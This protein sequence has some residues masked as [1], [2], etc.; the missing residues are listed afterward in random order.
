M[1][2]TLCAILVSGNMAQTVLAADR[3]ELT[4]YT[5]IQDTS[6]TPSQGYYGYFPA[7]YYEEGSLVRREIPALVQD[8][9][10]YLDAADVCERL[11]LDY[12]AGSMFGVEAQERK[13]TFQKDSAEIYIKMGPSYMKYTMPVA[14]VWKDETLWV[15]AEW[16]AW[17]TGVTFFPTPTGYVT[18]GKPRQTALDVVLELYD[19]RKP[20]DY[21]SDFSWTSETVQDIDGSMRLFDIYDGIW[22]L[23]GKKWAAVFLNTYR[24]AWPEWRQDGNDGSGI[25]D[26]EYASEYM[27][28]LLEAAPE[29]SYEIL[30]LQNDA[31][32][33]AM[34]EYIDT[35]ETVT[36][37]TALKSQ[38]ISDAAK[39]AKK[40]EE[41]A[42]ANGEF[43][44]SNRW[45]KYQNHMAGEAQ[46]LANKAGYFKTWSKVGKI[47]NA[48]TKLLPFLIDGAREWNAYDNRDKTALSGAKQV[49]ADS[50]RTVGNRILPEEWQ[51]TLPDQWYQEMDRL[52]QDY[53]KDKNQFAMS[54][55][56]FDHGADYAGDAA[57]AILE[58]AVGGAFTLFG[59]VSFFYNTGTGLSTNYTAM[60]SAA[61]A[62]E[63][64]LIGLVYQ[65]AAS[66]S[67]KLASDKLFAESPLG[68]AGGFHEEKLDGAVR[69][70]Y[71]FVKARYIT[72]GLALT[73]LEE[74][75]NADKE[76]VE[77]KANQIAEQNSDGLS[78]PTRID[79]MEAESILE[80]EKTESVKDKAVYQAQMALQA[81][82]TKRL[83]L[84]SEY[85]K[86]DLPTPGN[87]A[88]Q[89]ADYDDQYLAAI[90]TPAY[91]KVSGQCVDA[92]NGNPVK[93]VAI[94]LKDSEENTMTAF[95]AGDD[96]TF[97]L[98]VPLPWKDQDAG[99]DSTA[100]T[101]GSGAENMMVPK[102]GSLAEQMAG[103]AAESTQT[104]RVGNNSDFV[105]WE[106]AYYQSYAYPSMSSYEP[107]YVTA[108]HKDYPEYKKTCQDLKL[109]LHEESSP[110]RE[111][112]LDLGKIEL[113]EEPYYPYIRNK[114]LPKLGYVSQESTHKELPGNISGGASQY[115]AWDDRKGLLGADI[116][117]LDGDGVK[118]MLVYYF[119]IPDWPD[120]M[121]GFLK[122]PPAFYMDLYTLSENR[123]VT[124]VDHE[125]FDALTA[126]GYQLLRGGLMEVNGQTML[127]VEDAGNAYFADG[128]GVEYY[129]YGYDSQQGT[130]RRYWQN[131]QTGGGSTDFE[132]SLVEYA[133][134][135]IQKKQV[136]YAEGYSKWEY[137]QQNGGSQ[138]PAGDMGTALEQ[139]FSRLGLPTPQKTELSG[140][141]YTLFEGQRGLA[142]T[143]WGTDT[144]KESF[145]YISSGT[146]NDSGRNMTVTVKD[147]TELKE[148]I[149][150]LQ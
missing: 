5:A 137:Q 46:E 73:V 147:S 78:V 77:F 96:G 124:L 14:T 149:D 45:G 142:P 55:W 62:F 56:F 75:E 146:R 140:F 99:T 11:N 111:L 98:Y 105:P 12:T 114:L 42:L 120:W 94:T 3:P 144:L 16:F 43:M 145:E 134:D 20:F 32:D 90:I 108:T 81:E 88:G 139:G 123:E 33:M 67:M 22:A 1:A 29:E 65:Q 34:G 82:D 117:D 143:Y 24:P 2:G 61:E 115:W 138:P 107:V 135:D 109:V 51:N 60:R 116:A 19:D 17:T 71:Q 52:V 132:Y 119:D 97:Q 58:K 95:T 86:A 127:Y 104:D 30:D 79:R 40:F 84:L 118:D 37:S 10:A 130:L 18:L 113:G 7:Q 126:T 36:E 122:D 125:H 83:K 103:Q 28:L 87:W 136:L 38:G 72:R 35:L 15:P 27:K 47:G 91:V 100:G 39:I 128:G 41:E 26:Q 68:Q 54:Q 85:C 31:A 13:I 106:P 8:T 23:E 57:S 9:H 66:D 6:Y 141:E 129:W 48:G 101:A 80:N 110:V 59:Y 50:G 70:A 69:Q 121:N 133:G 102:T 64:S 76:D 148:H 63:Y 49:L 4:S 21:A 150:S 74:N 25:N 44:F 92:K 112:T 89:A 53:G 93:D 131:G